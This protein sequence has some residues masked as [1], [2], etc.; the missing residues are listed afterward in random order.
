M[1]HFLLIPILRKTIYMIK[2]RNIAKGT[3][4]PRVDFISPL[5]PVWGI[6]TALVFSREVKDLHLQ[7]GN[8]FLQITRQ[9]LVGS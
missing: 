6:T 8:V 1:L 7:W 3:T 4:D 5:F 9:R 2:K